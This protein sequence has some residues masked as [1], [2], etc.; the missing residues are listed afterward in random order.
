MKGLPD[1]IKGNPPLWSLEA[2]ELLPR[3]KWLVGEGKKNVLRSLPRFCTLSKRKFLRATD[4]V[5][6]WTVPFLNGS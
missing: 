2:L 3:V 4:P 1:N 6:L 5:V